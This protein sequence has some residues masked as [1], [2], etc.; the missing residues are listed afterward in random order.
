MI[1]TGAGQNLFDLAIQHCGSLE[2]A[3]DLAIANDLSLTDDLQAG[4]ELDLP[5]VQNAQVVQYYSVNRLQPATGITQDELNELLNTGEG[6]EF[7][8]IE[9]EFAV[10]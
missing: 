9:Y 3:F 6:I 1:T 4:Q 10:S 7:W 2:A 5:A 8:A